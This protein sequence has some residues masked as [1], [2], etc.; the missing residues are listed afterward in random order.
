MG[1]VND[2]TPKISELL[3]TTTPVKA[4]TAGDLREALKPFTDEAP[5]F[6]TA[7]G[8]I[9]PQSLKTF[10]FQYAACG[11][12]GGCLILSDS[13]LVIDNEGS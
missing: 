4:L 8:E 10:V 3:F 1:L 2:M 6:I 7:N 12:G 9:K 13:P 5:M 11:D